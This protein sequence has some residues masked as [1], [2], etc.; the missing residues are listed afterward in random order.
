MVWLFRFALGGEPN[1]SI[2]KRMLSFKFARLRM[3]KDALGNVMHIRAGIASLTWLET[4]RQTGLP[5]S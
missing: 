4:R 3:G 2:E 5:G 1:S